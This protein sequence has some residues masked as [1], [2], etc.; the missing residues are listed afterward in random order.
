MSDHPLLVSFLEIL[1]VLFM[2]KMTKLVRI[3]SKVKVNKHRMSMCVWSTRQP[4]LLPSSF[5][6]EVQMFEFWII[7]ILS[8]ML[9][10][11]DNAV[12]CNFW[13]PRLSGWDGLELL[14]TWT[15]SL[16]SC[17]CLAGLEVDMGK[18]SLVQMHLFS[19]HFPEAS[20]G[21]GFL[22]GKS[23]GCSLPLPGN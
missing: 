2:D 8:Q 6:P 13:F 22:P 10:V 5:S 16:F 12:G 9:Q 7:E 3:V 17:P 23:L 14:H 11:F 19:S 18:T 1:I 4:S 20:L 15:G 21:T